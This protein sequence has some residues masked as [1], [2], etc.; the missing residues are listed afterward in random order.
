MTRTKCFEN[1]ETFEMVIITNFDAYAIS[2][3]FLGKL[4]LDP[5]GG[6]LTPYI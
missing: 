1:D 5:G 6:G 2:I 4:F 3:L